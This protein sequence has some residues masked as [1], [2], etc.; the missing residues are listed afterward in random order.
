MIEHAV[1]RVRRSRRRAVASA[2]ALAVTVPAMW[3][4]GVAPASAATSNTLLYSVD[5]GS[6]WTSTPTVAPGGRLLARVWY[7][8]TNT[9]TVEGAQVATTIPAGFT[10][11]AGS[12]RLCLN[13][14]TTNPATPDDTELV[15]NTSTGQGG[16]IN[17]ASVW[18]GSALGISPTAGLYGESTG[19]TTGILE[20]G[21]KRY[22]NLAG[23]SWQNSGDAWIDSFGASGV[24]SQFDSP[25]NAS[26]TS[27]QSGSCGAGNPGWTRS[28]NS[29]RVLPL[30]LL[31]KRYLNLAGCG[32]S[33]ATTGWLD[34]FGADG[35]TGQFGA[36]TN[37]SNTSGQ[38]GSCG[39]ATAGWTKSG[40][41]PR[42]LP[43]D[44]LGKR[45]VN[46]VGCSWS[47]ASGGWLDSFGADGVTGTFTSPTNASNT[48]GQSGTCGAGQAGWTRA[49]ASPRVLT[50]DLLDT[51]RSAGFVEFELTAPSP[52][53]TTDY[54]QSSTL[55]GTGIT[56]ETGSGTI[57]VLAVD[58]P[59]KVTKT[60][61]PSGTVEIG[62]KV[63]YTVTI[64]NPNGTDETGAT[65]T[66]N[67]SGVLSAADWD[68]NVT[69]TGGTGTASL[70]GTT[71][72]WNGTVPANSTTTVTYTVTAK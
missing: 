23:C 14:S 7:D 67:L 32:W 36:P 15:C 1:R 31:G 19:A 65:F 54:P 8:S 42:V 22:V 61:S 5:G 11:V 51:T 26:N 58:S 34:S 17:E 18:S 72:T 60:A 20:I 48:S 46:V 49:G 44:L 47:T 45:Y 62:S 2:V 6:T 16:A 57:T 53:T 33:N 41:S 71:L 35:V 24:G 66:D 68:D 21:K 55:N 39:A 64:E 40:S 59:L 37:T 28:P 27:G 10:R 70:S 38:S 4:A 69:T 12:T 43:L 29:P 50:L 63:T 52:A 9:T 25:T 56:T 13:P 3:A 30:D